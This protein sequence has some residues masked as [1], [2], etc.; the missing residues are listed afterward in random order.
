MDP[1]PGD[2]KYETVAE[3]V[4]KD[5]SIEVRNSCR[6]SYHYY[7]KVFRSVFGLG[8]FIFVVRVF[9]HLRRNGF[10]RFVGMY[11]SFYNLRLCRTSDKQRCYTFSVFL[12][13]TRIA[14]PRKQVTPG[15]V[16]IY[17]YCSWSL[18]SLPQRKK[19]RKQILEF[20]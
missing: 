15:A 1:L 5:V 4:L 11:C 14:I 3:S 9:D 13:A 10:L 19:H 6:R 18:R 2:G 17:T 20:A 12:L 16:A 7:M 8:C